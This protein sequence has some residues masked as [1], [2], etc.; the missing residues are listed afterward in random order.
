MYDVDE[1]EISLRELTLLLN[2]CETRSVP[3]CV[4]GGWAT[5]FYV[6]NEYKRAYGKDYMGSRD[7]DIFFD[8]GKEKD[9]A[10]LVSNFGFEKNGFKFRYEKIY[11]RE[12]KK[13]VSSSEA[14]SVDIYNLIYIFLDIF[15][16]KKT[17][18]IISWH[19][20]EPLKNVQFYKIS[21]FNVADIDTLISLKCHALFARDKSDKENKDAC[22]L[23]ALLQYSKKRIASKP[24][25]IKAIEKILRRGDLLYM[26]ALHIIRDPAKQNIVEVSLKSNLK[27]LDKNGFLNPI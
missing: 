22:D 3:V 11:N 23:Y 27:E 4:I 21:G 20:L 1:T 17:S 26:I 6:N 14:K 7:I 24:I 5:Y 2:E 13:F 25:L 19:D 9:F 8:P 10:E 16:N 18:T 12:T 15:S